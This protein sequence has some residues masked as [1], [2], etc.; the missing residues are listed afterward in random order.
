MR[1]VIRI[2][3]PA[4]MA[5][6]LAA[7]GGGGGSG[8]SG[9][10]A[11]STE[12]SWLSLTPN[13]VELSTY[14]GES[15]PFSIS[16]TSSRTFSKPFNV[17]IVDNS[18]TITTQ[19]EISAVNEMTYT[20]R[21]YTSPKLPAGTR[22]ASIEVRLC[23][24]A[25]LTCS[26]P[27]PGSPWRVP[28]KVNVKSTA[29][30]A[31]RLALSP[32]SL[33]AET[34][35]GE[36]VVL[37]FDGVFKADL[38]GQPISVGVYDKGNLSMASVSRTTQGFTATLT[39]SSSLQQGEHNSNV[40]V[41]LCRDD[42]AVC[43]QP[44]SG[45]PWNVALKVLVKNPVNLTTLST[46]PGLGAW[47]T[48]QGDAAH[49]GFVNAAFD[50]AGFTRRYT[51]SSS[52][53]FVSDFNSA[54]IDNGRV[55]VTTPSELIALNEADGSVAWRTGI[56]P[57]FHVNSPA[58]ANGQVYVTTTGHQ[59]SY[60]WI[61]DQ[62]S[63]ALLSKTAMSSQWPSYRAPTV[64][65]NDVYSVD[66]TG[67][68]MGK[69]SSS[70][71]GRVW[72]GYMQF[73]DSYTPA[74]DT[75]NAYGYADGKLRALNTVDGNL[76]WEAADPDGGFGGY[77]GRTVALSGKYAVVAS[78]GR[79]MAFDTALHAS[80]WSVS[81]NFYSQP[82]V[83]NGQVYAVAANGTVL[84]ARSVS[85]GKLQWTSE[86][87][88]MYGFRELIV[89]QNLAFVSGTSRTVAIDLATHKVVW[90]YP[91]GGNLSVSNKGVLFILEPNGGLAAIN[92][93]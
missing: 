82:A 5:L 86:N 33:Q 66:G 30:G 51:V 80:A 71:L 92:L 70:T 32:Q 76:N 52:A 46:V 81:N 74:V 78:D 67:G 31:Q 72:F 4:L 14:E 59:D 3:L 25:P 65:G 34:Y 44:V 75:A 42:P 29:E 36:K 16:A 84:E 8:S 53:N 60:F 39:T 73:A 62:Q 57:V 45:S 23:E 63:G 22:Q 24:D 20:A 50:A 54:A 88:G 48:F 77:V 26:K 79:L 2:G 10:T 28:I 35:P 49:T 9:G 17:G 91:R 64:F 55:F 6:A 41:R 18:G 7:C 12:G 43:S 61:F 68:G 1:R 40:E 56:G 19:A 58:A 93:K 89:S 37:G 11:S 83:G 21:L 13:T 38:I 15:V 27:L 90:S 85:D 87:L 47:S 69:F